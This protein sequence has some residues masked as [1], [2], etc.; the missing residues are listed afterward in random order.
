MRDKSEQLDLADIVLLA[1]LHSY[2][3][4][5]QM[6]RYP[7]LYKVPA[8][9]KIGLDKS[10]PQKSIELLTEAKQEIAAIKELL[11]IPDMPVRSR[12]KLL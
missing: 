9:K 1:R 7:P 4:T 10:G 8:F 11:P 2:V 5:P 12:S 6:R 3:G